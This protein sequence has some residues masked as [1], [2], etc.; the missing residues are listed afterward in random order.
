MVSTVA[1]IDAAVVTLALA[2]EEV[3][4]KYVP[5]RVSPLSSIRIVAA[6]ST[7]PLDLIICIVP[8]TPLPVVLEPNDLIVILWLVL[9]P[10]EP[11]VIASCPYGLNVYVFS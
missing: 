2:L 11:C 1:N 10:P 7:F 8:P 5:P 9:A 3:A 4:W 6:L